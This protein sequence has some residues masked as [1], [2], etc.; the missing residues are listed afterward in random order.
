MPLAE[1]HPIRPRPPRRWLWRLPITVVLVCVAA[2]VVVVALGH[3]RLGAISLG[4]SVLLATLLRAVLPDPYSGMLAVR[5]RWADVITLGVLG[6][7]LL[8]FA[9]WVPL[10][11]G[12]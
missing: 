5:G 12:A 6:I 10:P 8:V 7:A 11:T 3:F 4:S 2:S 9:M 1:V